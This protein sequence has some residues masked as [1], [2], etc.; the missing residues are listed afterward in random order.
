MLTW[1]WIRRDGKALAAPLR[2]CPVLAIIGRPCVRH[3]AWLELT[4]LALP[5]H[6]CALHTRRDFSCDYCL[7]CPLIGEWDFNL[8]A[9]P[10]AQGGLVPELASI[11]TLRQLYIKGQELSGD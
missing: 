4:L 11:G 2:S 7:H 8:C 5:R 1:L 3:S 10:R 9:T 6:F